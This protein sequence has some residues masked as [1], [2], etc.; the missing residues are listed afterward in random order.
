M[1]NL[2]DYLICKGTTVEEL[3]NAVKILLHQGWYP[4]GSMVIGTA[5]S[6]GG[7]IPMYYQPMIKQ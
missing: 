6:T 5:T 1:A 3:R 4:S 2:S 7:I